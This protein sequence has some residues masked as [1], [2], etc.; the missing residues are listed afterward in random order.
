MGSVDTGTLL[1]SARRFLSAKLESNHEASFQILFGT[2]DLLVSPD[3]VGQCR[4]PTDVGLDAPFDLWKHG[5]R[6]HRGIAAG[7]GLQT[8]E[9]EVDCD[10]YRFKLRIGV[11]RKT[12]CNR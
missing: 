10:P 1:L 6:G 3:R 12:N 7:M 11:V 5:A 2:G 8:F 4:D 9:M